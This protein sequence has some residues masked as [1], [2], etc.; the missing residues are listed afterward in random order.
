[1][2]PFNFK[3]FKFEGIDNKFRTA[4]KNVLDEVTPKIVT[5]IEDYQSKFGQDVADRRASL[6]KF[7]NDELVSELK[8]IAIDFKKV[9]VSATK[10]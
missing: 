7:V 8:K 9:A 1:M 10:L 6:R 5:E 2:D 4:L 3:N